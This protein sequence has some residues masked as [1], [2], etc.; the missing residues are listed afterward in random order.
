MKS[1]NGFLS[2][3][4]FFSS[5]S[6]SNKTVYNER[7]KKD[8]LIGKCTKQAFDIPI[9]KEWYQKEYEAYSL[10]EPIIKQLKNLPGI[11]EIQIKIVFGTWCSDSRRELP[12]FYKIIEQTDYKIK[13]IK[14]IAVDTKKE[15]GNK[16]LI[17]FEFTRIPTFV[18]YK[19]GVETGRIIESP[20]LS[21]EEDILNILKK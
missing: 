16:I 21:L 1:I 17:D 2:L 18:F 13:K 5:C 3:I 15:S 7:T 11:N 10:N 12:R 9:F 8:I 20:E 4:I 14:L 6:I 19:N